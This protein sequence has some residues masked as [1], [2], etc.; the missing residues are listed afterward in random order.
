YSGN[1]CALH[2][3]TVDKTG[4]VYVCDALNGKVWVY[5]ADGKPVGSVAVEGAYHVAV[6]QTN[7]TLYVLTRRNTGYH[8]WARTLVKL[9]GLPTNIKVEDTLTFPQTG[10]AADPFL[11]VDFAARPTQIWVA[12]CPR[13]ES[14]LRIEDAG[15]LT[16]K[17]DLA[18]RGKL[19]SGF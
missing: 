17:E 1:I 9:S 19:A 10:G 14:V 13:Q 8:K 7:T 6:D 12:G 15:K 4:Q 5:G 3:V 2:G 11:A 16:I 18:E